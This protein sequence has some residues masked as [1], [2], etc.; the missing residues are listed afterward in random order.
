MPPEVNLVPPRFDA[1][2][3]E[4]S[5]PLDRGRRFRD[6]GGHLL[7]DEVLAGMR[8][9]EVRQRRQKPKA[10]ARERASVE[11][12]LA[13]LAAASLNVVDPDR[14]AVVSFN[15][16]DYSGSALTVDA[17]GRCRDYL[18]DAGLIDHAPGFR[19]WDAVPPSFPPCAP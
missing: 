7:V 11:A 9:N 10:E 3:L 19:R 16:N 13:N 15:R 8:S 18:R 12:L 4:N 17:L 14:F 1:E 6:E 5:F 2:E